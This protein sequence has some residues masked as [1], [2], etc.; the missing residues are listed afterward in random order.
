VFESLLVVAAYLFGAI[1]ELNLLARLYG[2]KV[3]RGEDIHWALLQKVGRTPVVIGLLADA[4]K[5]AITVLVAKSL[6]FETLWVAVAGL[7][8]VAGQMWPVFRRFDGERGCS[9]SL[10][11]MLVLA[12]KPFLIFWIPLLIGAAIKATPRLSVRKQSLSQALKLGRFPTG[13]FPLGMIIGFA[14]MPISAWLLGEP[15]EITM[16]CLALVTLLI[17]RRLTG[18]L[19]RDLKTATNVNSILINRLLY[20]RNQL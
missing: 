9:I 5:G 11:V 1:P 18:G 7:A 6:G 12:P 17:L 16:A 3:Q 10:G 13:S 15:V 19:K 20:D 4:A 14:T 2:I 8:A